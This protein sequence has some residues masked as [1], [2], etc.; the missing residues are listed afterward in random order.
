MLVGGVDASCSIFTLVSLSLDTN[1]DVVY[2]LSH[3]FGLIFL[4]PSI[5][6][7]RSSTT[8]H[9]RSVFLYV[10][11]ERVPFKSY[12]PSYLLLQKRRNNRI[13]DSIVVRAIV[14]SAEMMDSNIIKIIL[15]CHALKITE[16]TYTGGRRRA[17][18]TDGKCQLLSIRTFV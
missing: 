15:P 12:F 5:H 8:L 17:S 16:A 11:V 6:S 1:L 3:P 18:P 7:S 2:C 9:F 10:R 4:H 13:V 14:K